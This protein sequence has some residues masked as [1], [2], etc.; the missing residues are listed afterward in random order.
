MRWRGD[1]PAA[2]P[3]EDVSG[4]QGCLLLRGG[5]RISAEMLSGGKS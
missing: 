3:Q 4:G 2:K 5:Q 1:L